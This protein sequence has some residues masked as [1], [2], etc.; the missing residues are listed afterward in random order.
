MLRLLSGQ[1]HQVMSAVALAT[2]QAHSNQP[3]LTSAI[4]VSNVTFKKLSNTEIE[5][6][7]RSGECDDKAG[8]YAIQGLAAAFITHLS[9]SYSGVM[10]LPLY[11]T[12][13][14]L[15]KAGISTESLVVSSA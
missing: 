2:K 1:T 4:S 7:G 9:G 5:Q 10:G 15:S 6:Y 13:E 8:A 11:E 14:L 3:E 12:V